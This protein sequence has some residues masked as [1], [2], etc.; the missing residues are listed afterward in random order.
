VS[1][2]EQPPPADAASSGYPERDPQL[3][4]ELAKD[5]LSTQLGFVDAVDNKL[6]LLFSASS[7]LMGILVAVF[8]IRG[9]N[10]PFGVGEFL[11]ISISGLLYLVAGA[12][13]YAA[14]S[15]REWNLGPELREVWDDLWDPDADE[16]VVRWRV[17]TA[18]WQNYEANQPAQEKKAKQLPFLVLVIICQVAAL[19]S[20]LGLVAAGG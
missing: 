13:T 16:S 15:P 19:C 9:V 4:Y 11:I 20:A 10:I 17:A 18:L 12:L 3:L 5:R 2:V 7:A 8:A 6:G 14:Y 1:T